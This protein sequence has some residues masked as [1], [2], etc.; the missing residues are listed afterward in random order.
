MVITV[1]LEMYYSTLLGL[2][3]SFFFFLQVNCEMI[4]AS[5]NDPSPSIIQS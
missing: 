4:C 5:G 2:F 3:F 1:T